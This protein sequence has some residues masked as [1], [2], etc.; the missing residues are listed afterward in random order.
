MLKK[1]IIPCLDIKNGRTVKGINFQNLQDAGDAIELAKIYSDAGADELVFLDISATGEGRKTVANFAEQVA[2]SISIPFTIGGG[3]TSVQSA[4][5]VILAGADKVA[6][7]SASFLRPQLITELSNAFGSQAVVLAIDVKK[8]IHHTPHFWEVF[9]S[10][11]KIPT[12]KNVLEWALEAEK[13]GA[14]EILL[15]TMDHDG[16]KQGFDISLTN[17]VCS[18]VSIPVIASGGGGKKEH[19]EDIFTKTPATGALAASIF[20]FGEISIPHLK[21]FLRERGIPLR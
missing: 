4:R 6:V 18:V 17:A 12:G 19:F 14:G 20:H 10:G 21:S 16:T 3:I 9:I 13:L 15:T 1:R 8:N 5:D 11:G 2:Q 7:N